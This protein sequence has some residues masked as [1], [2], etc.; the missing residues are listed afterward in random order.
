VR[1]LTGSREAQLGVAGAP[2]EIVL[3]GKRPLRRP[4]GHLV[5]G[6]SG[7]HPQDCRWRGVPIEL[8]GRIFSEC[9]QPH[10]GARDAA[11][12]FRTQPRVQYPRIGHHLLAPF[13]AGRG[14]ALLVHVFLVQPQR[15][16]IVLAPQRRRTGVHEYAMAEVVEGIGEGRLLFRELLH[17]LHRE[18]HQ[19]IPFLDAVDHERDRRQEVQHLQVRILKYEL[20]HRCR[21]LGNLQILL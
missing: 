15:C 1:V 20:I 12:D 13:L 4:A 3:S 2:L 9:F 5:R 11:R 7:D 18:P 10:F 21:P 19:R 8:H 14:D 16:Q 6:D 17:V